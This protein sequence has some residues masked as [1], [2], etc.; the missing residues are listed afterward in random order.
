MD[1][2]ARFLELAMS[3]ERHVA[4]AI[5]CSVPGALLRCE[6]F[7][8]LVDMGPA[9]IPLIFPRYRPYAES[10]VPWDLLLARLTGLDLALGDEP[11]EHDA[12]R[13]RWMTWAVTCGPLQGPDSGQP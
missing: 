3:W 10:Q 2:E 5:V 11:R 9:V 12:I 13:S 7:A 8:S 6:A 4:G 1:V